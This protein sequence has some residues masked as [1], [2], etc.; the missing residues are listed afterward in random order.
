MK[1]STG[2]L[3]E[4][5]PE[6]FGPRIFWGRRVF[7]RLER[8]QHILVFVLLEGTIISNIIERRLRQDL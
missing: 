5:V 2:I 6:E 7:F 4:F 3:D 8:E 1:G